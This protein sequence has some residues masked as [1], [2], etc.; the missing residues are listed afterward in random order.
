LALSIVILTV[1][2][3]HEQHEQE[4]GED[5]HVHQP[6]QDIGPAREIL[7]RTMKQKTGGVSF[8]VR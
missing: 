4:Y 2:L 7:A 3:R 8:R 1:S 5:D 6:K